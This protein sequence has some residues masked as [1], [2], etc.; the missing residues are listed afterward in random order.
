M[1]TISNRRSLL[2]LLALLAC[3]AFPAAAPAR[4]DSL[5]KS[6]VKIFTTVQNP[7]YYE[8]W[9]VGAQENVSGSGCVIEGR[10]ILTNA[11]VVANQIFIQ[12][13]KDGDTKK[14]TAKK[15][16]V[17]NDCDLAVLKVDDPAFFRGTKPVQFG[18]LPSLKDKVEVYG[19]PVGGEELSIT[20]GGIS[21]IE[22]ITYAHSMKQLFCIQTN[23]AINPGNSGGPVFNRKK[24]VGV[25]FQG[26]NGAVAQNTGYIVPVQLIKRFLSQVKKKRY[27]PVPT[28]GIYTESMENDSLR[29]YYGMKKSQMGILVSQVVYQGSAWNKLKENDV[30]LSIDGFPIAN[31]GTVRFG[32]GG[33]LNFAYPLCLH[34]IGDKMP[35][36]ILRGKKNMTVTLTLKDD[37]RLVPFV[38]YDEKPSYLIFGGLVFTPLNLN[39]Y[40]SAK[41]TPPPSF[42]SLYFDGLPSPKRK[43]VV[44]VS[45]ILSHEI[46]KGYGARYSNLIVEKVNGIPITEMKDL[47]KALAQPQ[48]GRQVIE[49]EDPGFE[50]VGDKIVL[51]AAKADQA[52]REILAKNNILADRSEDL[53]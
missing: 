9:M 33:R 26:Y 30:L 46:N 16:F 50:D 14:Y 40:Q 49:F 45:H 2:P 51:D 42:F 43:Q 35:C 38:K 4:E 20:E 29:A 39:Y 21:R 10:R 37:A 44:L 32:R 8:P 5:R 1:Q 34:K 11:H 25:A 7:N 19:Y 18:G 41:G 47:K 24:M 6:L 3:L 17:A 27:S 12:V 13:L 36:K 15:E 31:D 28:L 48:E 53:K 23:A 22:L 52:T